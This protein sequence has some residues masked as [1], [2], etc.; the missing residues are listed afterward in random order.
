MVPPPVGVEGFTG[1]EGFTG[2]AGLTGLFECNCH[3][4]LPLASF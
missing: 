1:E 2:D 3:T 4:S